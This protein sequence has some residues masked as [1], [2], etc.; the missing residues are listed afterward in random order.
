MGL[1]FEL[2]GLVPRVRLIK[3]R[4]ALGRVSIVRDA[5]TEERARS[6]G[7]RACTQLFGSKTRRMRRESIHR[8]G[9]TKTDER[10]RRGGERPTVHRIHPRRR[11]RK[12]RRKRRTKKL[13][14]RRIIE[15]YNEAEGE[16][17]E[18]KRDCTPMNR[19]RK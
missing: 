15:L 17:E 13:R 6:N 16:G 2:G 14:Y 4:V 3:P 9:R 11:E 1:K 19:R 8:T 18:K 10:K 7:H 12:E 5:R